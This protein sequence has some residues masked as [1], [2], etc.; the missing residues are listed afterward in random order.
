MHLGQS[1]QRSLT[2]S[3]ANKF[4]TLATSTGLT[5]HE[6]VS[7]HFPASPFYYFAPA[8]TAPEIVEEYQAFVTSRVALERGIAQRTKRNTGPLGWLASKMIGDFF[9]AAEVEVKLR[10]LTEIRVYTRIC[11]VDTGF[12]LQVNGVTRCPSVGANQ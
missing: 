2:G 9:S 3:L 10:A 5:L 11:V 8:S 12:A 4:G 6:G 7:G 1:S